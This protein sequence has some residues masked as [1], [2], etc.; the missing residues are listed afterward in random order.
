MFEQ[1]R[2]LELA[3]IASDKNSNLLNEGV[4][5]TDVAD[6]AVTEG[7]DADEACAEGT[8]A[9]EAEQLDEIRVRNVIRNEIRSMLSRM[10]PREKRSWI[11]QGQKPSTNSRP[12]QV[13]RGF[14]G[15]GFK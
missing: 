10:N 7:E 5:E 8:E 6:T 13:S 12:G 1:K 3:G 11:L 4:N 2:L 14:A 15:I 9:D